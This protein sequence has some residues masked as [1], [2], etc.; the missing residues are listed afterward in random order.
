TFHQLVQEAQSLTLAGG[1]VGFGI[2]QTFAQFTQSNG[3]LQNSGD[4][5]VAGAF[6]WTG[7]SMIGAGVTRLAPGSTG[8]ISGAANKGLSANR[9]LE[10][11]GTLVIRE[12]TLYFNLGNQGGG[13]VLNNLAGGELEIQGESDLLHNFGTVSA[14]NNAG[15]LRKTG[16]GETRFGGSLVA[17]NN[18]GVVEIV[19]GTLR[20]EGGGSHSGT[21]TSQPAGVLDLA[22]GNVTFSADSVVNLASDLRV[23]GGTIDVQPAITVVGGLTVSGGDT[24]FH[25][26]VQE[27]QSLTLAGGAVGF[28]INQTFAQFTQSNGIL[29]NS[30]D[31]IVTGAFSWTGGSMIGAGVTRLAPGSTG[32]ISGAAN[33]GLSAKRVLENSGTLVIS[34]G[35]LYFNLGNQGGGAV[36]NNLAGAELEIQGESDLLHNFGTVSAVNNAGLLR[37]T[38]GGETR[39]GGSLV[40]LNNS[41]VVEIV[42]GTLRLE[43]GGSHSGTITSQPAGVLDL[44]GGNVTFSADSVVNLASDLR[45]SGGT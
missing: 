2:N 5:I 33:K 18:S 12:G 8:A 44:A 14:V 22:G 38:G 7:G 15:L 26:L 17:L 3:I 4:V 6:S 42:D 9:V 1:A 34:E 24:T 25:Q 29:Q 10:N 32:A 19:E 36:L 37:K 40:A 31:V 27:A 20:L 35:T 45:V 13:A 11:G 41:G 43:G 28:G 30:G 16:G 21:I 23:S 39:F